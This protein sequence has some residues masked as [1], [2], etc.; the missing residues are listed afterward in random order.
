MK[1]ASQSRITRLIALFFFL[2]PVGLTPT[3]LADELELQSASSVNEGALSFLDKLP[4]KPVHH[5]QNRILI[6]QASLQSGWVKLEQCHDNLDPVSNAQITFRDGFVRDLRI[7]Q[8]HA[9]E[10]AWIENATVQLR[11]VNRGA[12]LCIEAQTRALKNVGNGFF[13]LANGPYMRKF[14]DG[15]YPMHISL[16]ISYPADMLKL[17]D[18]T[19]A[20]QPGFTIMTEAGHVTIEALFEGELRTLLQFEHL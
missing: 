20:S 19:P 13:N 15:Y 1:A 12:R 17:L 5:H 11:H 18:I 16:D 8:T 14:L 4:D 10:N 7:T 6:D 9:I 2:G 3:A